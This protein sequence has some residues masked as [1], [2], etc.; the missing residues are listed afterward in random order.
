MGLRGVWGGYN[1]RIRALTARPG[2]RALLENFAS[3]SAVQV[4][5]YLFPLITTPYLTR[6]LGAER[7]G[8]A[9]GAA[10]FAGLFVYLTN[11][12]FGIT[13]VRQI[14]VHRHDLHRVSAIAGAILSIKAALLLFGFGVFVLVVSLTPKLH[15]E[16]GLYLL[17]FGTVAGEM[18]Y[19]Q[20]LFQGLEKMKLISILNAVG[21]ALTFLLIVLLISQPDDYAL[22]AGVLSAVQIAVGLISLNAARRA[23]IRFPF[24][25][26]SEALAQLR[27]GWLPFVSA[28]SISFYT[29]SRLFIFSLFAANTILG[30][31][32]FADKASGIVQIF[33]IGT[34]MAAVLPRLTFMYS[35]N[36]ARAREMF[37][38]F[39][40][41]TLLY[42]I[43]ALPVLALFANE[44]IYLLAGENFPESVLSFRV[45]LLAV[46]FALANTFRVYYLIAAGR[47]KVFTLI[48]SA[49]SAAGVT[50]MLAIIPHFSYLG[51]ALSAAFTEGFIF[52]LTSWQ[53]RTKIDAPAAV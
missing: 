12:G 6:A 49:G 44:I 8:L 50:M 35:Q 42:L 1:R 2:V 18:L 10:S 38:K 34:L 46:F 30:Y 22:Y 26:R 14:S 27:E 13:A 33:P 28:I 3:L 36:P 23:G 5:S 25:S 47:Y 39:Q 52:A 32:A 11:Y 53:L 41:I 40:R 31:Y 48:H 17:M 20:W 16:A 37:N 21:K 19:P 7:F 4:L 45:Q 15:G 51:M 29:Q 43:I 9:A 24:P